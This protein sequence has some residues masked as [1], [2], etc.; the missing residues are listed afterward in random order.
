M[1]KKLLPLVFFISFQAVAQT[2]FTSIFS[3]DG[4]TTGAKQNPLSLGN[5]ADNA[6]SPQYR[7]YTSD[8]GIA[9]LE[10]HSNRWK[11]SLL[12]TRDDPSGVMNMV[13][14]SG[15]AGSGYGAV[16]DVYDPNNLL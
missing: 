2:T 15:Y 16:V 12:I 14:L 6:S 10:I 3:R 4:N 13:E 8:Q 11:G 5:W 9:P 7:L 1:L